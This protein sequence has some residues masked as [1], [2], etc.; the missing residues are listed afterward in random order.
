MSLDEWILVVIA[1]LMAALVVLSIITIR[2]HNK[3]IEKH[4]RDVGEEPDQLD[5]AKDRNLYRRGK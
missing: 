4:L 1:A 2:L 5:E 3:F